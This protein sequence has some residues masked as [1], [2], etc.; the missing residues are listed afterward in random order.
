MSRGPR[1]K[2]PAQP[3]EQLLVGVEPP[4]VPLREAVLTEVGGGALPIEEE[5]HRAAIGQRAP[6]VGI[7]HQDPVAVALELELA[8]HQTVE[9][10]DDVGAGTD[11][12]ARVRKRLLERA[13]SA[14]PLLALEHQHRAA[15]S[16]QIGGSGEPVVPSADHDRVP[17]P[18]GQLAERGRQPD[19]AHRGVDVE[20]GHAA[21]DCVP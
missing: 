14:D 1:A 15:R 17:V 5:P 7:G 21:Y 16:R 12:V 8:D 4:D 3:L 20:G 18:G 6:E 19:L 9:Q 13:R 10:S 11:Q 2:H